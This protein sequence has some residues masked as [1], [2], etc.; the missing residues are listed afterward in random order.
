MTRII[1]GTRGGRRL[2][3]PPG[4]RTRPTTDRVREAVFAAIAVWAGA[5]GASDQALAGLGFVDLF[6]GSG[7]MALEAASRGA[8]PV[9]AVEK[10]RSVAQVARRNAR[11]LGLAVEVRAMAVEQA[12]A[13]DSDVAFD[14]LWLD[15][16]YAL[17]SSALV[18]IVDAANRHGWLAPDGL[19]VAERAARSDPPSFG[20]ARAE[21]WSRRYGETTVYFAAAGG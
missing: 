17:S 5:G 11:E 9:V 18:A 6:S 16:P 12:V 14:V 21:Q 8:G 19:V 10:D 3:V 13:E 4:Q 7:A 20:A 1:A 15:P 2:Q